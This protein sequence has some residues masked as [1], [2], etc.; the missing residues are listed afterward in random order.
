[1]RS[2]PGARGA[3]LLICFDQS[4]NVV[5]LAEVGMQGVHAFRNDYSAGE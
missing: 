1:M 4:L 2:R 3:D 5:E